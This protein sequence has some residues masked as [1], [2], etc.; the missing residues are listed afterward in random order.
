[1]TTPT[2]VPTTQLAI[3]MITAAGW[4]GDQ[5]TGAPLYAGPYIPESPD[6]LVVLTATSGPGYLTDEGYPDA[7]SFQARVRGPS[8]DEPSAEM[9]AILLDQ[10][11]LQLP[12]PVTIDGVSIGSIQR[13]GGSP[14]ALPFDPNDLRYDF[15]CNYVLNRGA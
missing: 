7:V 10:L 8:D 3:D 12:T 5:E 1:M 11:I 14:V 13:L 9:L 6:R 15:T 2:P 4:D